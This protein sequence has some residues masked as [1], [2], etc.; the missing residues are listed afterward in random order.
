MDTLMQRWQQSIDYDDYHEER[1]GQRKGGDVMNNTDCKCILS[2]GMARYLLAQ[3]FAMVDVDRSKKF[4]GK[5]VFIFQNS[6]Q[7]SEALKNYKKGA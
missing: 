4:Q 3:G 5:L 2:L 1:F 7:L 6:P